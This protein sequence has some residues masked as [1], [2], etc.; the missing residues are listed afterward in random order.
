MNLRAS[1]NKCVDIHLIIMLSSQSI[2]V[3]PKNCVC[4]SV[5]K[6]DKLIFNNLNFTTAEEIKS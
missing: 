5:I 2:N 3:I 1:E 4:A 6:F